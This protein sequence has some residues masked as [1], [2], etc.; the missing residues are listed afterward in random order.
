M[1]AVYFKK[2]K[3]SVL[4]TKSVSFLTKLSAKFLPAI[5]LNLAYKLLANPFSKKE[6]DFVHLKPSSEKVV[7][8]PNGAVRL[9]HFEAGKKSVLL[10]HGWADSSKS[11]MSIIEGLNKAGYSV[12]CFDH[13]AHGRSEGNKAHLFLFL[14][15]LEAV[16]KFVNSQP[17]KLSAVIS[18]SM[19]GAA[20]LNSS[21]ALNK[22]LKIIMLAPPLAFFKNM[23][24]QFDEFGMARE[25]LYLM[26]EEAST[27]FG[28]RWQDLKIVK[29]VDKMKENY[30]IIHD[31][32]DTQ[33]P[34]EDTRKVVAETPAKFLT[35]KK[36]GHRG[37]FRD[38]KVISQIV[39]FIS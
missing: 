12:Y 3:S 22:K 35:T 1:K 14:E 36:L 24:L 6:Y 18:H 29:H 25:V 13:I 10:T 8:T 5:T 31:Q 2:K 38:S 7:Q 17:E 19:G 27:S 21:A 4:V 16:L 26:L 11:F 32:D 37:L 30:F 9:Y 15:G 28:Q 23:F 33:V 39:D 34:F 20:L